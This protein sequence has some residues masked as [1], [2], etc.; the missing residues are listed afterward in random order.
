M[1][2]VV[3]GR[4]DLRPDLRRG[5]EQRLA[6]ILREQRTDLRSRRRQLPGRLR[7]VGIGPGGACLHGTERRQRRPNAIF[8]GTAGSTGAV[9]YETDEAL[10]L[11]ADKDAE[12]D[13]YV[14]SEGTTELVSTGPESRNGPAP[15]SFQ[16][17]SPDGS[18]TI[19]STTEALTPQD[20]D[21]A[22]DVYQR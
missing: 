6:R 20:T 12:Q 14:R 15:I 13:V 19:F 10:D 7:L 1:P 22:A 4:T 11:A 16:W 17:A 9:Y 21:T 2:A 5:L 18:V 8:S 3:A